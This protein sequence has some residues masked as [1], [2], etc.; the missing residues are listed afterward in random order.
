MF[1]RGNFW[2]NRKREKR[3]L[4][5][6]SIGKRFYSIVAALTVI[7]WGFFLPARIILISIAAIRIGGNKGGIS[8]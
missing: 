7:S 3:Y 6:Y 4:T 2:G 5:F 8:M 1:L